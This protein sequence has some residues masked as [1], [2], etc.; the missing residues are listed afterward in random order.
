MKTLTPPFRKVSQMIQFFIPCIK[1]FTKE[2]LLG[3]LEA[4]EASLRQLGELTRVE[5]TFSA[6][7]V[8]PSLSRSTSTHG[9]FASGRKTR[10]DEDKKI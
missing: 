5:T 8:W 4:I 6:L 7:N 3:I 1:E 9:D 2:T 10:S